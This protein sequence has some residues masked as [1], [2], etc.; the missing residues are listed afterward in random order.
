[1][2]FW[3]T[4]TIFSLVETAEAAETPAGR[5]RFKL[6]LPVNTSDAACAEVRRRRIMQHTSLTLAAHPAVVIVQRR[7]IKEGAVDNIT[8]VLLSNWCWCNALVL[9]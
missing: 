6:G 8:R 4:L 9:V 5:R 7:E 2:H 3:V 1:M